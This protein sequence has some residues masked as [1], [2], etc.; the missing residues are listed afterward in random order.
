LLEA[1]R[2]LK[3]TYWAQAAKKMPQRTDMP[4]L[5]HELVEELQGL[6]ANIDAIVQ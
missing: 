3:G 2:V 4:V 1:W 6:A 5:Y